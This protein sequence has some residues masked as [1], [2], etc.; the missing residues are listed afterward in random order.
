ML[1]ETIAGSKL[2]VTN[3]AFPHAA[4][5]TPVGDNVGV[6]RVAHPANELLGDD[7]IRILGAHKAVYLIAIQMGRLGAGS[8]L[9]MM[10][11]SCGCGPR[12][13]AKGTCNIEAAMYT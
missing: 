5:P 10:G 7:S 1:F 12:C 4:I 6:V 9:K 3:V 13:L 2:A 11:Q 8:A